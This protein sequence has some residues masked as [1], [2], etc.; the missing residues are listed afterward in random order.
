MSYESIKDYAK[1]P[2]QDKA[3]PII[4]E[5]L[6]HLEPM[7]MSRKNIVEVRKVYENTSKKATRF[8]SCA[9]HIYNAGHVDKNAIGIY[10]H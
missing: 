2:V 9:Q 1:Q 4:H 8:I 7:D 10:W 6:L 5:E 3:T